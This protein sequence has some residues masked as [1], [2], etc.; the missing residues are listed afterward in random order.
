M[1]TV[2]RRLS[3]SLI[4][5]TTHPTE[6]ITVNVATKHAR[7]IICLQKRYLLDS[8]FPIFKRQI[9]RH[10]WAIS[11]DFWCL[12]LA[13]CT[14]T[15]EKYIAE[16]SLEGS[17][18]IFQEQSPKLSQRQIWNRVHD[19]RPTWD[20]LQNTIIEAQDSLHRFDALNQ[21]TN[22]EDYYTKNIEPVLE[23]L[24]SCYVYKADFALE[25]NGI[26][27]ITSVD[28]DESK[29]SRH[30]DHIVCS[31]IFFFLKDIIHRHQHHHPK[32]DTILDIYNEDDPSW[33]CEILRALYKKVLTFKRDQT[34]GIYSSSLGV[35]AYIKAFKKV[36]S[37]D[38][39]IKK[40]SLVTSRDDDTLIES[41][42]A[43][44]DDLRFFSSQ[45][46]RMSDTIRTSILSMM[47]LILTFSSLGKLL[48]P[49]LEIHPDNYII[50]FIADT[51]INNTIY[52]IMAIG[53]LIISYS[54]VRNW[55]Y[56]LRRY[57]WIK[58]VVKSVQGIK[59]QRISGIFVILLSAIIGVITYKLALL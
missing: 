5:Q 36:C 58:D 34:E 59:D 20:D 46:Q 53:W 33:A 28:F 15:D 12:L 44:Q 45:R 57:Y 41:I 49:P 32:T 24:F 14:C 43:A 38:L 35:L 16:S 3:F 19:E 8:S 40:E 18:L 21:E 50:S 54:Y 52:L 47:G 51:A 23:H 9:A 31:Q 13:K 26:V 39:N 1:P 29:T 37:D 25:R 17:V 10:I 48:H 4:G 22:L 56:C 2:G 55:G 30:T 11:G 6:A 7:Y 42:K 27:R